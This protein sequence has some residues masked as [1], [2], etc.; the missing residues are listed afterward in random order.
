[1]ET[2]LTVTKYARLRIQ[3]KRGI[4]CFTKLIS[5]TWYKTTILHVVYHAG[6]EIACLSVGRT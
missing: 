4:K 5:L 2:V 3:I 6:V 1:M